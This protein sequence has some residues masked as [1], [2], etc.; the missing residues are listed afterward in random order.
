MQILVEGRMLMWDRCI[1]PFMFR[2][3]FL[4]IPEESGKSNFLG[5]RLLMNGSKIGSRFK[6]V[7]SDTRMNTIKW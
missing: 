6:Q 3:G 1:S 5:H 2:P 7:A 4:G